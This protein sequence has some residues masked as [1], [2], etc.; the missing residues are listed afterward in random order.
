MPS[1]PLLPRVALPVVALG[2][3]LQAIACLDFDNLVDGDAST[4]DPPT[5]GGSEAADTSTIGDAVVDANEPSASRIV[6]HGKA[7]AGPIAAENPLVLPLPPGTRAGDLMLLALSSEKSPDKATFSSDGGADAWPI[8]FSLLAQCSSGA[9][10]GRLQIRTKRV[11]ADEEAVLSVVFDDTTKAT[12]R[13]SAIL[14]VWRGT[15][16]TSP[17]DSE[18]FVSTYRLIA[19][20]LDVT[21]PDAQ[22]LALY[23]NAMGAGAGASWT[24]P[25]GMVLRASTGQLAVFDQPLSVPGATGSRA[26]QTSA[27]DVCGAAAMLALRPTP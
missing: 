17:I 22:L 6:L 7:Q 24:A 15:D 9:T 20:E 5:D 21:A 19:P 11:T 13:S 8:R 12:E 26:A 2:A 10:N 16:P 14:T 18:V 23:F 3:L 27:P 4:Y 1:R 25:P